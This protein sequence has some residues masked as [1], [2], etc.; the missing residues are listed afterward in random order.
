M[1]K[2]VIIIGVCIVILSL[3]LFLG[4]WALLGLSV[5]VKADRDGDL[6]CG[7]YNWYR[8]TLKRNI[9]G[10]RKKHNPKRIEILGFGRNYE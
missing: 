7:T 8:H 1:F 2:I 4:T 3:L 9:Y 6:T 10:E 5:M